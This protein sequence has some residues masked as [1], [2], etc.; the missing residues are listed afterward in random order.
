M[1]GTR[2]MLLPDR[3]VLLP[4]KWETHAV[5]EN[6][7]D[8]PR[9]RSTASLF[10]SATCWLAYFGPGLEH[11]RVWTS[12]A[13][14]KRSTS[15][16]ATGKKAMLYFSSRPIDPNKIDLK[17]HRRL[18]AFEEATYSKALTGRFARTGLS[19]ARWCCVI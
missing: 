4:V 18:R 1:N 7:A 2:S 15:S 10:K 9:R 6:R 17:Q 16:S 5:P 19:C 8:G 3:V 11:R 13:P 14:W 12:L